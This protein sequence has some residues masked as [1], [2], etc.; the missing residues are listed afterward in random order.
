VGTED[1]AHARRGTGALKFNRAIDAVGVG[2]GQCSE[3]A[4]RRRFRER[5]RAGDT[6]PKGE[7][8]MDV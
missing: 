5:F 1:R 3:A 2:A 7:M 6:E 4:L 8:G